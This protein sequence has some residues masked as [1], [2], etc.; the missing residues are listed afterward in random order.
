MD[1]K[2]RPELLYGGKSEWP[3]SIRERERR[4]KADEIVVMPPSALA[5]LC[6]SLS[7]FTRCKLTIQLLSISKDHG[8]STY[9]IPRTQSN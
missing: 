7:T 3:S 9:V 1:R 2:D 8:H 4:N 5:K 6:K